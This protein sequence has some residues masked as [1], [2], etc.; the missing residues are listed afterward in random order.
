MKLAKYF[1]VSEETLLNPPDEQ[2]LIYKDEEE[3]GRESQDK[4]GLF[5]KTRHVEVEGTEFAVTTHEPRTHPDPY[6]QASKDLLEIYN[7]GDAGIITAIQANLTTFLR[8]VRRERQVAQ[9]AE[10]IKELKALC[11]EMKARI[12]AL[13]AKPAVNDPGKVP[14]GEHGEKKAM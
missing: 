7:Y 9:Q 3:R 14:T 13:E 12:T 4:E 1:N 10:E 11:K 2:S 6:R 8:T 5:G